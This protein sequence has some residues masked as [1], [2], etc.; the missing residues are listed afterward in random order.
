MEANLILAGVLLFLVILTM[1]TSV[2]VVPQSEEYVIER[3]GKYL[4]TLAPGLNLIIPYIHKVRSKISILERQLPE[5]DISVITKDNVEI[6]LSTA[7]FFRIVDTAKSVYRIEDVAGAIATTVVST[8]RA[9]AGKMDFDEVQSKRAQI[10]DTI[11]MELSKAAMVWG[12]EIT[13]TE[14]LDVIV[15]SN[16]KT[17]MRKQIDAERERRAVVTEA[18]GLKRAAELA[19]DADLYTAQKEA[20]ARRVKAEAEAYATSTVAEAINNKGEVA[21]SFEIAKKQIEAMGVLAA[22]KGAKTIVVPTDVTK[23]LG[24]A[25]TLLDMFKGK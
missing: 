12:I 9:T 21:A 14:I 3:F 17:A 11:E 7:V 5:I 24:T 4:R 6:G 20:E 1:L 16:T 18:E 22:S 10:N 2:K 15:D 23:T 8:V 25:H 13:R 19:A